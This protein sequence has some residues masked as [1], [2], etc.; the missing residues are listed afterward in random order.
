MARARQN[1]RHDF[2][3]R[4][5]VQET[6]R[7]R[8]IDRLLAA[9]SRL[10]LREEDLALFE[11]FSGPRRTWDL[12]AA[13]AEAHGIAGL[14]HRHL[15]DSGLGRC[16]P[17]R[18]LERLRR[19]YYR[20]VET[21][22]AMVDQ[23][24]QIDERLREK[25]FAAVGLQ[26]LSVLPLYGDPGLRPLG[27]LDLMV[28]PRD[29]GALWGLLWDL[30]Y[31]VPNTAF[32]D[33][34]CKEGVWIDLHIHPMNPDRIRTRR[35]IFPLD[36]DPAWRRAVPMFEQGGGLLCLDPRD[37]FVTLAAHAL[38]HNYDRL[39]WMSDLRECVIQMTRGTPDWEELVDSARLWKQEYVVLYALMLLEGLYETGAP[40]AVQEALGLGGLQALEKHLLR[41]KLEGFTSR[42]SAW[43]CGFSG[44]KGGTTGCSSHGRHSSPKK[45]W[46]A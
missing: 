35:F 20:T 3:G 6:A 37:N 33:L 36:F 24:R 31:R 39:I 21:V 34:L 28:R 9:A 41:L 44:S 13:Q 8:D 5:G 16:V 15:Q 45:R 14:L 42:S 19:S 4:N 17:P 30:G 23:A 29:K 27:D 38:K 12:V 43:C 1:M 40:K 7:G 2:G 22:Q 26:G 32:P 11:T 46:P 25:G 10:H 18:V